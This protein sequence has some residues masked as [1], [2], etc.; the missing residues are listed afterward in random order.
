MIEPPDYEEVASRLVGQR[1]PLAYPATDMDLCT[2]PRRIRTLTHVL[3]EEDL[4]KAPMF[5]RDCIRTYTSDYTV[6]EYKYRAYSGSMCGR[7]RLSERLEKL[8]AVPRH[9]YEV[10]AEPNVIEEANQQFESQSQPSSG[11]QSVASMSSSSSCNETLTPRGSWASLDLRSSSSDPLLPDLF[12]RK[13]AEQ[14]DAINE[15]KRLENRQSDLLGLYTPYLDEEEAVERRLAAEMPCE[16]MGH[17]ILVVCHQLKLE[18][19]I[20]PLFASMA[21]YDAKE[22]KKLSENFYFNLN[23]EC[24]RQMVSGHIPHAD[25]STLSR[26]A[27]FDIHN[28]TPDIFLVVRVEKVLQ[29]DV[30]ECIEPYIKDDK[31]REKVRASAQAACTRLGKYR[32]PLAW[33]CV[34]LMNILNGSNSLERDPDKDSIGGSNTNS[35]GK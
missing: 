12:E 18:L 22:R 24:T 25:L 6:A 34:S 16:V 2:I 13:P 17:R 21:L 19:D 10:D 14:L 32:M 11:R 4:T 30:N 26:S 5:V 31:N 27:V 1:D 9:H 28:P 35:L 3:P 15:A 20:E 23:S 33:S 8:Q 29:G 7:E